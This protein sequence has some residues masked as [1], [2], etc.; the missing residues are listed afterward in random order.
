[1][2]QGTFTMEPQRS[3]SRRGPHRIPAT[4]AFSN[5][6]NLPGSPARPS[7]NNHAAQCLG[8]CYLTLSHERVLTLGRLL[9]TWMT[10]SRRRFQAR[11]QGRAPRWKRG[12]TSC[13]V[14]SRTYRCRP[15]AIEMTSRSIVWSFWVCE[16][17]AK[18]FGRPEP[19][20]FPVQ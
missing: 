6:G 1:M 2:L 5:Q 19:S 20:Q 7:T 8:L 18:L 11:G 15:T 16:T 3:Y 17:N 12:H 10:E 9:K 4:S 13:A 14:C